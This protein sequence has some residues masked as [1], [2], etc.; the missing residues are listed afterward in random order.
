MLLLTMLVVVPPGCLYFAGDDGQGSTGT[1]G[2]GTD[3]GNNGCEWNEFY[4]TPNLERGADLAAGSSGD[5]YVVGHT[6]GDLETEASLGHLDGFLLRWDA[7]GSLQWA[8]QIGT[9]ED[10]ETVG[11]A[12][13]GADEIYVVG[14]TAGSIDGVAEPS[15]LSKDGFV[16]RFDDTGTSAWI[17]QLGASAVVCGV[18]ADSTGVY[19]GGHTWDGFDFPPAD[20]TVDGFL[21]KYDGD[22]AREWV[23]QFGGADS[24]E[25]SAIA[26]DGSGAT[27]VVGVG[28]GRFL[29]KFD[30]T[31]VEIWTQELQ[32]APVNVTVDAQDAVYVVGS[33]ESA[34]PGETSAGGYDAVVSSYDVDG[35]HRWSHQYGG[36]GA[37]VA[38]D[39]VADD[40]GFVYVTGGTD[41]G[42]DGS[43]P[44]G[45]M[46]AF[47]LEIDSDGAQ[48]RVRTISTPDW[49]SGFAIATG[50]PGT[51]YVTGEHASDVLLSRLCDN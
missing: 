51:V 10:D 2:Q 33:T 43:A 26:T 34:L 5:V 4:G 39:V 16:A 1:D 8:E 35:T 13:Q 31:G 19:A 47:V 21:V 32:M 7:S 23:T 20:L 6:M 3:T 18:V 46:D 29:K 45:K 22:G 24:P 40:Q 11:I 37:D 36:P 49:E 12:V 48:Q 15:P 44:G 41:G 50:D 27:Y 38:Y 30:A 25:P 17:R 42:F 14:L 28:P 9:S